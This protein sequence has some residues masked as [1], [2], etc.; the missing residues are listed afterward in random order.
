MRRWCRRR[1]RRGGFIVVLHGGLVVDAGD[2]LAASLWR[3]VMLLDA[4]DYELL[5]ILEIEEPHSPC[6]TWTANVGGSDQAAIGVALELGCGKAM[7]L[8]D[9]FGPRPFRS[10]MCFF[11]HMA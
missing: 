1:H 11:V 6:L 3:W 8:P 9:R 7:E 5:D 4:I 10:S 2:F